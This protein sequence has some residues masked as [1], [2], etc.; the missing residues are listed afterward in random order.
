MQIRRTQSRAQILQSSF[1]KARLIRQGRFD[2][3]SSLESTAAVYE[4][5]GFVAGLS[6]QEAASDHAH[7]VSYLQE[8]GLWQ[9]K[10]RRTATNLGSEEG[11]AAYRL[12]QGQ[13]AK[14]YLTARL[15]MSQFA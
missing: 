7:A 4:E 5:P 3:K 10:V 1:N 11:A 6:L 8:Q 14:D 9:V 2:D 15:G 12:V 13:A